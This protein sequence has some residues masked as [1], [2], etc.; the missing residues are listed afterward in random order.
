MKQQKSVLTAIILGGSVGLAAQL[1]WSQATPGDRQPGGAPGVQQPGPSIPERIEPKSPPL[2]QQKGLEQP[3][4]AGASTEDI[5]KLEQALQAKG[6]NPGPVD[7]IMDKQTQDAL[8][9]FQ[10]KNN[11]AVTGNVDKETAAK[12]G[13]QWGTTS[14]SPGEPA[15]GSRREESS[16]DSKSQTGPG[17]TGPAGGGLGSG[18]QEKSPAR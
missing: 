17:S 14:R 7:G 18:S 10:K 4:M 11:L 2:G 15:P 1:A 13:I 5:R 8:R 6:Y 16:P 12:L 3:G 9:E